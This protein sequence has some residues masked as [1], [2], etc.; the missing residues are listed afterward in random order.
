[1]P[2][3]GRGAD[4]GARRRRPPGDGPVRA[5]V[6]GVGRRRWQR[7]PSRHLAGPRL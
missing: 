6:V 1:A 5:G 7:G 3:P 2:R 4:R